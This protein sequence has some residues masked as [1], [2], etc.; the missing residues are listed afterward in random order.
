MHKK[1]Y[2][3][4]LDKMLSN[5]LGH[6]PVARTM[7]LPTPTGVSTVLPSSIDCSA[8]VDG[9]AQVD[10]Q[11]NVVAAFK[12]TVFPEGDGSLV[13]SSPL[14]KAY[15]I[16]GHSVRVLAQADSGMR[17]LVKHAPVGAAAD[18]AQSSRVTDIAAT[19]GWSS[20]GAQCEVLAT[21]DVSG[22]VIITGLAVLVSDSA[23][24]TA[25]TL[26]EILLQS[27]EA[28]APVGTPTLLRWHPTVPSRLYI[29]RGSTI[30]SVDLVR[31]G[32]PTDA[33]P[34]GSG[35]D[36]S[37][38]PS[39]LTDANAAVRTVPT[40]SLEF[41]GK[42][43][44]GGFIH[45]F[46]VVS[47]EANS[48]QRP[49]GAVPWDLGNALVAF[50]ANGEG[51]FV[52]LHVPGAK[53]SLT[54]QRIVPTN[55][56]TSW[57]EPLA[58]RLTRAADV[59]GAGGASIS[60]IIADSAGVLHLATLQNA[61]AGGGH[62][63]YLQ[64]LNTELGAMPCLS[65]ILPLGGH[66]G[67]DADKAALLAVGSRTSSA[68]SVL[69]IAPPCAASLSWQWAR[70]TRV[71]CGPGASASL[72]IELP[73]GAESL[74]ITAA[75]D[76]AH[77]P[78]A[79]HHGA[80][81][82]I[83]MTDTKVTLLRVGLAQTLHFPRDDTEEAPPSAVPAR[84]SAPPTLLVEPASQLIT[85]VVVVSPSRA[86]PPLLLSAPPPPP[87]AA[88]AAAKVASARV[89]TPAVQILPPPAQAHAKV[90]SA[91]AI[92]APVQPQSRASVSQPKPVATAPPAA[93]AVA[94]PTPTSTASALPAPQR[95]VI[96]TTEAD[97]SILTSS[98]SAALV[99]HT[100]HITGAIAAALDASLL[101]LPALIREGL[102]SADGPINSA[103]EASVSRSLKTA[104]VTA[105]TPVRAAALEAFKEAFQATAVPAF[106][107]ASIAMVTQISAALAKET[108]ALRADASA[109]A[110]AA[111][112]AFKS[113]AAAT[114]KEMA[115]ATAALSAAT[116]A[117][118]ASTALAA[119]A[120]ARPSPAIVAAAAAPVVAPPQ[121]RTPQPP[122]PV[123]L[124]VIQPKT[125]T[126][127]YSASV[128]GS[129][130]S[131][132]APVAAAAAA[133][134]VAPNLHSAPP[135]LAPRPEPTVTAAAASAPAP[136]PS[137]ALVTFPPPLSTSPKQE[138]LLSYISQG[139]FQ[140]ALR[141]C[142]S[143]TLADTLFTVHALSAGG[144]RL[145][146]LV[147]RGPLTS[148]L[149]ALTPFE[150]LALLQRFAFVVDPVTAADEAPYA[151]EN[152]AAKEGDAYRRTQAL[153]LTARTMSDAL[154]WKDATIAEPLP[155]MIDTVR[156]A[157]AAAAAAF[158]NSPR[159]VSACRAIATAIA[160]SEH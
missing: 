56:C 75:P 77:W 11:A 156:R 135:R 94:T 82:L 65:R 52:S 34:D 49:S 27:N 134:S 155:K 58:V 38:L 152:V 128:S 87:S 113:S 141:C 117:L 84:V 2:P 7:K 76:A 8:P 144:P 48:T 92:V 99:E 143:A 137:Q 126:P 139:L 74:A 115:T 79:V 80:V 78:L 154:D 88:A 107:R 4:Y 66:V 110:A 131:S 100:T 157:A 140:D 1:Q 95:T 24:L 40:S 26:A 25:K 133:M 102:L 150:R 101:P 153:H 85:P 104:A 83:S 36:S 108:S 35:S 159:I 30:W 160:T 70:S 106:E 14:V 125:S 69:S 12:E 54:F 60:A 91:P 142:A 20:R 46:D 145:A 57:P 112:A 15:V 114:M 59:T 81:E 10:A 42:S 62:A 13:V 18:V 86:S 67:T 29:A 19:R 121:S 28:A 64:A 148:G 21:A 73:Y 5:L 120:H 16:M 33:F 132:T 41:V 89:V 31:C 72:A 158:P 138:D 50:S 118:E 97:L 136:S 129:T 123:D 116:L 47:G 39:W 130:A 43:E 44:G 23:A 17:T 37:P 127:I 55:V 119:Q 151:N 3:I 32:V 149:L 71:G 90:A 98:I 68:I 105:L 111:L 45:S 22:R 53:K 124:F 63:V 93:R 96:N 61:L 146:Q 103:I 147:S 51:A 122:S 9:A 109:H 6:A